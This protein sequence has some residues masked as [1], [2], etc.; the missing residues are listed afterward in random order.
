MS[1]NIRQQ[2]QWVI[3]GDPETVNSAVMAQPG[4]LGRFLTVKNASS[5]IPVNA[6]DESGRDK[7]YRCIRVDSV[8]TIAPYRGAVAW[9]ADKSRFLVTTDPSRQGRGRVAGVFKNAITKG[10]FGFIQT[11]GPSIVSFLVTPT[12]NPTALGL[13]VIP[14]AEQ[15]HADCLAAGSAATYPPLGVSISA[16]DTTNFTATVDLQ[17]SELP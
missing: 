15:G 17:V 5:G 7:D 10:N 14:S 1:N 16:F 9:W 12:A 4:Q 13:I 2:C 6:G 8:M 11:G 3:T